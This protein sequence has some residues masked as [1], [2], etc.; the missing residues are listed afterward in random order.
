MTPVWPG[1]GSS[2]NAGI[3][4]F[5]MADKNYSN[6]IIPE[7]WDHDPDSVVIR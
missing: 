2:G 7:N 1:V 4:L 6:S 5:L 3:V